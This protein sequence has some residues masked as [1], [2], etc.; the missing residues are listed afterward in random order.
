MHT[1]T[2]ASL[3]VQTQAPDVLAC[4][5][6]GDVLVGAR[7]IVLPLRWWLHV[8][9]HMPSVHGGSS[10]LAKQSKGFV[11]GVVL[12]QSQVSLVLHCSQ[13]SALSTSS[14]PLCRW[15][16]SLLVQLHLWE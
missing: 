9:G 11:A 4:S 16:T 8:S 2:S 3:V 6:N 1:R 15:D 14:R 12:P 5:A 10:C 13:T 7:A